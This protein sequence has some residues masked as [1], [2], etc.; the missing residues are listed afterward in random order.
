MP[1][2]AQYEFSLLP[3]HDDLRE[4]EAGERGVGEM[5]RERRKREQREVS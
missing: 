5:E 2:F 4:R 1:R 3:C